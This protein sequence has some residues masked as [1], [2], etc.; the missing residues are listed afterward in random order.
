LWH[1][2]I[3]RTHGPS[4]RERVGPL[5]SKVANHAQQRGE[6]VHSFLRDH[7]E[8]GNR[9][10]RAT[11]KHSPHGHV[12]YA[13]D[14]KG[15]VRKKADRMTGLAVDIHRFYRDFAEWRGHDFDARM[16]KFG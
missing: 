15:R 1:R 10:F 12:K 7:A 3:E 2:L 16:S 14:P 6:F 13:K 8:T 9:F 5:L 11:S 4:E